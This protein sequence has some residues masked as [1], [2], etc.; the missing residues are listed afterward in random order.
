MHSL[1]LIQHIDITLSLFVFSAL[2]CIGLV[3]IMMN[4]NFLQSVFLPINILYFYVIY[5][6][7]L[8]LLLLSWYWFHLG[9]VTYTCYGIFLEFCLCEVESM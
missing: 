1:F 6:F 7:F 5:L 4:E 8:S 9:Q 3:F 2:T